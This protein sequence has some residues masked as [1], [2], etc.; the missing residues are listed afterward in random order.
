MGDTPPMQAEGEK[1]GIPEARGVVNDKGQVFNGVPAAKPLFRDPLVLAGPSF[2]HRSNQSLLTIA[3]S[4]IAPSSWCVTIGNGRRPSLLGNG[5]T[6]VFQTI[7][8]CSP[9]VPTSAEIIERM[10]GEVTRCPP[11]AVAH[12]RPRRADNV[13]RRWR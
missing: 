13:F 8:D 1:D 2:R 6:P 4:L 7:P 5:E 3:A 9:V 11:A 12:P 10:S